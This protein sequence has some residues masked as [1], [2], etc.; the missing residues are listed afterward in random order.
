MASPRPP[1][2]ERPLGRISPPRIGENR[3]KSM[4]RNRTL[5]GG[6]AAVLAAGALSLGLAAPASAHTPEA[7]A[8]CEA[9]YV[10]ATNYET[11]PGKDAIGEPTLTVDNPDYVPGSPGKPAVGEPIIRVEKPNPDFKPATPDQTVEDGFM[12]WNWTGG[13]VASTP[14][15][16]PSP[17]WHQ[18]GRTNDTKG[19]QHGVVHKGNGKGSYFYYERLTKVIPGTPAQGDPTVWV[20]VPNPDFVPAVPEVPAVGTPTIEVENPD[21]VAAV[22]GDDHP[23]NVTITVDGTEVVNMAFG[24][25]FET[26]WALDGT[27]GHNWSVTITAWNDPQ[28]YK[29]WTKTI[30]GK[31]KACAPTNITVPELS[32]LPPTCDADGTL[33]FLDNPPAQNPNGYEFPGQGFRV[34]LDRAFDGPGEYTAT[35]QKVGPGFDPAFPYGTKITGGETKQT[36]TVLP[37]TGFQD[38]DPE[39]PCYVDVPEDSRV[40]GEWSQPI[41]DCTSEVGDEITITREVT[42]TLYSFDPKTGSVTSETQVVNEND[43]YIVTEEDIASLECEVPPTEEPPTEEPPTKPEPKPAPK[44]VSAK[45]TTATTDD[46]LAQTGVDPLVLAL[47]APA[48]VALMALGGLLIAKRRRDLAEVT[49]T[50]E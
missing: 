39:A 41:F 22:P 40:P 9:V 37:A 34:Y 23:N 50:Q 4:K 12:K 49:D 43:V 28:G 13:P 26:S 2:E 7:W 18:V 48:A 38:T 36:L 42:V 16:P 20:N 25:N 29:G 8:T 19:S 1:L 5:A 35:L 45:V 11:K 3:E 47:G 44:P 21:Y 10:K 15:A 24:K 27:K 6:L 32:V 30:S 46:T 14:P 33:P 17:G 31:T